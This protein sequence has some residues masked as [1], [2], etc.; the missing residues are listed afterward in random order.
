MTTRGAAV[1]HAQDLM[2]GG[3]GG[4]RRLAAAS[5]AIALAIAPSA[6]SAA[7]IWEMLF[8]KD[9]PALA[10]AA[11]DQKPAA[12]APAQTAQSTT[13]D[14][15]VALP[16]VQRITEYIELT[17]N[18]TSV[19]TVN[20]IARV[21]GVLEKIHFADGQIVKTGD[22][23]FT[24]QQE[25]YLAQ[26]AQAKAQLRAAE[27]GVLYAQTEVNRYSALVKQGAA[28][29]VVVDNW[30][31]N[32]TKSQS[33]VAAAKAQVDIAA[34]NLSYTEVRAPFDGLM[35]RHLIDVGNTVGGP[36]QRTT[37]A[38]ILQLDPIYVV[39]NLSEQ[40]V[41]RVRQNI[42]DRRLTLADLK[43][44]PVDVGLEKGG[45][46]FDR[47]VIEYVAPGIDP[48][49][50]TMLVR[51]ILNNKNRTLLPGFFVRIRLPQGRT[52][53]NALL[54]PDRAIQ[55]DQGGQYVLVAGPDNVVEQRHITL[56]E[57]QGGLRVVVSGLGAQ[58]RVVVGY[59]WRVQPG[60]KINVRQVSVEDAARGVAG[61]AQ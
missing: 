55:S 1:R 46:Y 30:N 57:L 44:V 34:L 50:G 13:P 28:S 5:L 41:L 31:F 61:G 11:A 23:L 22:L 42:G 29:Q 51:G 33:D 52:L 9:K 37:L 36:G 4:R 6:A 10:A 24:I 45:D 18:A 27:A 54:I 40:E 20:L 19:N 53:P 58:D 39:A 25:Q 8:G 12:A 3:S 35:G 17:G 60:A 32:L 59:L 43:N 49:T 2:A 21:E 16:K 15:P 14:I 38:E 7:S 48:K 47:G 56:G 26:L